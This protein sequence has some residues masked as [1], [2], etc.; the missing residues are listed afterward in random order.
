MRM[1]CYE[2]VTKEGRLTSHGADRAHRDA[3]AA[4]HHYDAVAS[5]RRDVKAW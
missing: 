1:L 4:K 2:A 3:H 5:M